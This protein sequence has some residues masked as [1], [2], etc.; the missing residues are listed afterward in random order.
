MQIEKRIEKLKKGKA[1]PQAKAKVTLASNLFL[2]F[3]EVS[4]NFADDD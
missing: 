4:G 3:Q 1:N 2:F